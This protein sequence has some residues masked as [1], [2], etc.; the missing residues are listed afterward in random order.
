[1]AAPVVGRSF[2]LG[3]LPR[4]RRR[5][6]YAA[7]CAHSYTAAALPRSNPHPHR[8]PADY[9]AS[10]ANPRPADCDTD[11]DAHRHILASYCHANPRTARTSH[12]PVA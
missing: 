11:Q 7:G 3:R 5:A 9:R 2:D 6:D 1:M 12:R 4:A 8:H 10:D